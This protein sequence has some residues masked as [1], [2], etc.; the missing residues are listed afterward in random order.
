M[1]FSHFH[2]TMQFKQCDS[3]PLLSQME[4]VDNMCLRKTETTEEQ[5]KDD[6]LHRSLIVTIDYLSVKSNCIYA[7]EFRLPT[8]YCFH[9][10]QLHLMSVKILELLIP[11]G[12]PGFVSVT[13]AR[14]L[15]PFQ[16]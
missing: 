15:K 4:E 16:F 9:S 1:P 2:S 5:M 11:E 14:I 10:V 7:M 8:F 13:G 3:P 12:I 6:Q